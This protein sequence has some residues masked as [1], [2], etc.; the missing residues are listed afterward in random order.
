MVFHIAMHEALLLIPYNPPTRTPV[1]LGISAVGAQRDKGRL[2]IFFAI[3]A[4]PMIPCANR[5]K[6]LGTR[7]LIIVYLIPF[8]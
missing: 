8:L 3:L 1:F 4:L 5:R 7:K 2:N 6:S